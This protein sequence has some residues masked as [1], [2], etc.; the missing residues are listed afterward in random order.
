MR[1]AR[2]RRDDG[3]AERGAELP[4]AGGQSGATLKTHDRETFEH[5]L[6]QIQ[7]HDCENPDALIIPGHDMDAWTAA[8]ERLSAARSATRRLPDSDGGCRHGL[9]GV[10]LHSTTS[11]T[12]GPPLSTS[13]LYHPGGLHE[14]SGRAVKQLAET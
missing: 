3:R 4:L 14:A 7:R 6:R 2:R 5:S 10:R 11:W 1:H 13:N 12:S 8:C 9:V